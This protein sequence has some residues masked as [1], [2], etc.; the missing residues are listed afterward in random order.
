MSDAHSAEQGNQY[1]S[2]Q[3]EL[4]RKGIHMVSLSIPVLYYFISKELALSILV[5]L[6]VL[7]VV[8]DV[9]RSYHAPSFVLYERIF[10]RMLR[11]HEKTLQ[12][13]TLNGASW[14]LISA[15]FCV[16]VFPKLITITAFA[17]L[18]ISDTTA[19]LVGRRFGTKKF[20]D[21][22]LEGST[23]F[24]LSAFVVIL[25]TP[26]VAH[27]PAEYLI[28][29][30]SAIIGALA[31]VFSFDIIDDNFAIPVSIGAALWLLYAI[32]LPEMNIHLLDS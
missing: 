19:A 3:Y 32:F 28:A 22:T 4:V 30:I 20:N 9:L 23:A 13:K 31:E 21:K 27:A 12:K 7:F 5:P 1:V 24:V 17:I 10:G 8:A 6:T 18:I 14:V 25:F 15:T 2:F 16:L 11:P 29:C 26:K